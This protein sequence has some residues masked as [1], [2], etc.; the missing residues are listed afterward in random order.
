M[1]GSGTPEVFA[2]PGALRTPAAG[3]ERPLAL[4]HDPRGIAKAT[5]ASAIRPVRC[6][7]PRRCAI[8]APFRCAGR[9]PSVDG[10]PW[11]ARPRLRRM[12]PG[13]AVRY[14]GRAAKRALIIPC[15]G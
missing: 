13:P 15:A 4:G 9:V 2:A 5:V 11:I 8:D 14:G 6:V 3:P 1:S 7:R 12:V 10:L